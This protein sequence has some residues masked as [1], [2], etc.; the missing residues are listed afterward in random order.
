MAIDDFKTATALFY[1]QLSAPKVVAQGSGEVAQQI[2]EIA[3]REGV[4]IHQDPMLSEFL[5]R[6]ETGDEIPKELYF[7]IAE[8]LAHIYLVKGKY[9]KGFKGVTDQYV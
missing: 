7:I 4:V 9:P 6:L 3:K 1:D 2:I 8:I 5:S